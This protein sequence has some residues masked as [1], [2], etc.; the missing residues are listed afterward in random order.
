[1]NDVKWYQF[2]P[3]FVT[4]E[5]EDRQ[6]TVIGRGVF[7]GL[8][9]MVALLAVLDLLI[10]LMACSST[11][12]PKLSSSGVDPTV[13]VTNT[14]GETVHLTWLDQVKGVVSTVAISPGTVCIR[15]TVP[16]TDSVKYVVWDSVTPGNPTSPA[17]EATSPWFIAGQPFALVNGYYITDFWTI[18]ASPIGGTPP[19][20]FVVTPDSTPPC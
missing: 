7:R 8:A 13:L 16:T 5:A 6:I 9:K 3:A 15:D 2:S 20:M 1:M 14:S 4:T 19:V 17:T 12:G 18:R 10:H 11:T